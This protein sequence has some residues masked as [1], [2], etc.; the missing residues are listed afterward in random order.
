VPFDWLN[1]ST[2]VP[3]IPAVLRESS[4][5]GA[6]RDYERC[7]AWRK[8]FGEFDP[9]GDTVRAPMA[10]RTSTAFGTDWCCSAWPSRV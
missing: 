10:R 4:E 1:L 5:L 7:V 6:R 8:D 2:P 3:L 9:F